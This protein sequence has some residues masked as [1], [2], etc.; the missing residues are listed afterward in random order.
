MS[1]TY[2]WGCGARQFASPHLAGPRLPV[3]ARTP[4]GSWVVRLTLL[5]SAWP[6]DEGT[7]VQHQAAGAAAASATAS[8]QA[9]KL[10]NYKLVETTQ[11]S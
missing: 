3:R 10:A 8:A 5:C 6:R 4:T 11:V 9:S 1:A 7:R 2:V